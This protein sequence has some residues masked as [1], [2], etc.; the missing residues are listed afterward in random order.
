MQL[1]EGHNNCVHF[2]SDS[3][4]RADRLE[5][6][7]KFFMIKP[8]QYFTA[9]RRLAL[10]ALLAGA[11]LA[12]V[13]CLSLTPAAIASSHSDAPLIKLDPQANLTDVYSFI[14]QKEDGQKFLVVEVSVRPFSEPGDGVMYDS[15]SSDA[16]YSVHL[17]NP[18]TGAEVRALRFS[19]HSG[20]HRQRL[21]QEPEHD[22][23]LWP[24]DGSWTD[25]DGRR[26]PPEFR[27][28]ILGHKGKRRHFNSSKSQ[29]PAGSATER[30]ANT[31]RSTMAPMDV[32][33]PAR[34]IARILI[35]HG[36]NGL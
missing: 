36:P 15:F 21:L 14:T 28:E 13:A 26:C 34:P 2:A 20:G 10:P 12:T 18:V 17:A 8:K 27:A 32:R 25:P 30:G 6:L 1:T 11:V 24:G 31:T 3:R 5:T 7:N 16:L 33:S 35:L 9:K 23:S 4:R 22:S 19:L 29:S